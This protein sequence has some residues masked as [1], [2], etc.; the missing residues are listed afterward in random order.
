MEL[1]GIPEASLDLRALSPDEGAEALQRGEVDAVV[2]LTPWPSPAVRRLLSVRG[3]A[4][5]GFPRADVY[6]ALYPN[7]SKVVLP[8]G[9]GDLARN[10]PTA[11]VPLLAVEL[12]LVVHRDLHPALQ[13]VL[14]EA[15]AEI[16]G[17][18]DVFSRAGRFPAP[19][20]I[21]L[22]LSSQARTFYRSGQPFVYPYLPF[23]AAALA[24]RLLIILIPLFAIV[25]P[26]ASIGPK[27]FAYVTERRIFLFYRE[28]Q[29]GGATA[30]HFGS[31]ACHRRPRRRSRRP[32][33]ASQP[34]EVTARLR[35]A[36]LLP[37]KPHRARARGDRSSPATHR[38][39]PHSVGTLARG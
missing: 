18:P 12:N 30:G 16:H 38:R 1:N 35:A 28:L 39:R 4:L 25:F 11:D 23:W 17:G 3:V 14:L 6:V 2:M 29:G 13:Y 5:E 10:V 20:T 21:D 15:A 26:I 19:G 27:I 8:T 7:L 31:R 22:P 33:P 37:E 9:A 32:R 36:T 34:P 24:E